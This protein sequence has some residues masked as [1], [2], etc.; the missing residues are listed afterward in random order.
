MQ[1]LHRGLLLL[2]GCSSLCL[3]SCQKGETVPVSGVLKWQGK[4]LPRYL[5]T[6]HPDKGRPSVGV[7]DDNGRFKMVYTDE[8]NGV[9]PGKHRVY[10]SFVPPTAT[11]D[12]KLLA[13][14]PE[15]KLIQ[16]KYG[17][18]NT[19]KVI[20]VTGPLVDYELAFE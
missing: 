13:P 2:A 17:P 19:Q 7:S 20:D 16:A 8:L 14:P 4:P 3:A 5:I 12:R 6:F 18:R 1:S 10:L 15:D 11:Y 9:V